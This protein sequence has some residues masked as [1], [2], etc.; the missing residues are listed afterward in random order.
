MA[1]FH[2]DEA[3]LSHLKKRDKRLAWA[4]EQIGMIEREVDHDLFRSLVSSMI[5]QQISASAYRTVYARFGALCGEE[6]TPARVCEL[7]AEAIQRCGM[8]MRKAQNI[9]K[10]A[11]RICEGELDLAALPPL[12]DEEVCAR[13][14]SF[15]GI[16]TWTAEML[17][18]F[19]MERPDIV[20]YGDLAIV[21]G[22]RMLYRR[23][24][25]D[26][27]AFARYCKRYSPYGS[28]AS[29]YLWAIA[30]GAL[31]LTDPAKSEN[32]PATDKQPKERKKRSI[33][34]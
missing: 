10:A 1:M 25:I 28:V 33:A 29:L 34:R 23:K 27:A 30:G 12:A 21:R 16:G 18:L 26:K 11:R 20:S 15:D 17:M 7:G 22:M 4:I 13:L 5:S 24:Q 19:S 8:S 6:V 9:E 2:Y 14:R 32:A 3:A 31:D